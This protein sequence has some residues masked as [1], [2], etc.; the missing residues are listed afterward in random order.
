MRN[1]TKVTRI[2]FVQQELT[3]WN[4]AR[5]WPYNMHIGLECG[6][7]A[8]GIEVTTLL[9]SWFPVARRLCSDKQFDQIWINDAIHMFEP[10]GWRHYRLTK[11]D[12][13]WLALLAPVRIGFV[14]ESLKYSDDEY[15]EAPFLANYPEIL[16]RTLPYLSHVMVVDENDIDDI[17][18]MC[19]IPV[20]WFV[21]PVPDYAISRDMSPPPP[22]KPV[23]RGSPYGIRGKWLK[24]PVIQ[25]V[26]EHE[27]S[28]DNDTA[29]PDV[30]DSLH[31]NLYPQ[32]IESDVELRRLYDLYL[33]LVRGVRRRAFD[34]Y[35]N[36][37]RQGSSVVNLP[38][39]CKVYAA[40]VYE[41]MAAG[42][43]VITGDYK[44]RPRMKALFENGRDIL[45]YPP[46]QPEIL[47]E[48]IRKVLND[49]DLG[50][51]I[52]AN[53][54]RK[55]IHF[56]STEKWAEQ[57]L[58]WIASGREAN[59]DVMSADNDNTPAKPYH[60]MGVKPEE[61]LA[62]FESGFKKQLTTCNFLKYELFMI[63]RNLYKLALRFEAAARRLIH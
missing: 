28:S 40:R 53:A 39:Y 36:D 13:E 20:G 55:M 57:I 4:S 21:P 52:A 61:L 31:C 56:H 25:E 29:L 27:L 3:N 30:F 37:L 42:R 5:M 58:Q 7:A 9:S 10:K 12:L 34:L 46:D 38:S 50:C 2:L 14:M 51:R 1:E 59:F 63:K 60:T 48:Q 35:M 18:S 54:T 23:F 43:P 15:A 45:L 16:K 33:D 49:P 41:A 32:A 19:D 17:R 22:I 8:N 47:A 44:N 62:R 6:F 24:L 11:Q 26:L